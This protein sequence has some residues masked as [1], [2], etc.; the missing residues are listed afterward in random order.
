V[1][2]KILVFRFMAPISAVGSS[3]MLVP[4]YETTRFYIPEGQDPKKAYYNDHSVS[5]NI[6]MRRLVS[7]P[8]SFT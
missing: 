2:I 5:I 6:E 4:T 8:V 7:K 1:K 3:E